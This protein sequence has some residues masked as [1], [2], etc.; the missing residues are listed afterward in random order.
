MVNSAKGLFLF[1]RPCYLFAM[2]WTISADFFEVK[3]VASPWTADAKAWP[4]V[5]K[6]DFKTD[7]AKKQEFAI[8]LSKQSEVTLASAF[9]A[10][11]QV[12]GN[13]TNKALWAANNWFNDTEVLEVV[14]FC[15][16]NSKQSEM[17]LDKDAFALK[18]LEYAEETRDHNGISYYVVDP[19]DRLGYLRLYAEVRGYVGKVDQTN[20]NTFIKE[21]KIKLIKHE[22][23]EIK[24]ITPNQNSEI[25]N[26]N[27]LNLKLKLVS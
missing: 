2:T 13:D 10:G 20:N 6:V 7:Q 9:K 4:S 22:D 25:P 16:S 15:V 27:G 12:F 17:P 11:C 23:K 5:G 1:N 3:P 14:N 21:M 18:V 19:K 24:T 26:V 8:A